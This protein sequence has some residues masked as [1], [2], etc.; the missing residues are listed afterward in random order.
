[1]KMPRPIPCPQC[2]ATPPAEHHPECMYANPSHIYQLPESDPN[3]ADLERKITALIAENWRF[4]EALA[5]IARDGR[6]CIDHC[7][8]QATRA[9]GQET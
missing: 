7:R 9:L 3:R 5:E 6:N 2:S 4:K 1:V 8:R